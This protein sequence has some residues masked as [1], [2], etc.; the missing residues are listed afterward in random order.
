MNQRLFCV[1]N[2]P[3]FLKK[4]VNGGFL[5]PPSQ[6][7]VGRGWGGVLQIKRNCKSCSYGIPEEFY[8]QEGI[9]C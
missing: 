5:K 9:N 7:Y 3:C 1:S 4:N 2:I 8:L 6:I